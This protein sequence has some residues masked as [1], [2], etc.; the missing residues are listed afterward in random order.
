MDQNELILQLE[1]NAR[2]IQAMVEGIPTDQAR[3]RPDPE[4]WSLL[5]VVNHL[6]DEEQ[7]DFRV[8]LDLILHNP[9]SPWPP[10]DPQGWVTARKYNERELADSLQKFMEERSR[11]LAWLRRLGQVNWEARVPTP[12]GSISAGDM[13]AAWVTHDLLHMR[14]LVEWLHSAVIQLSQPYDGEYAGP[15]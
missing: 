11:S 14:Q 8:R 5:E 1:S 10:I 6:S 7:F 12:W 2:R 15:W 13:L 4:A 3:R 9:S